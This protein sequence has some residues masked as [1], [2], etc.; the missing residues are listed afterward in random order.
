MIGHIVCY[1]YYSF[2][3]IN[4]CMTCR[5]FKI[6]YDNYLID[7]AYDFKYTCFKVNFN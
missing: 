4:D 2:T 6:I 1:V 5:P 7:L 3:I